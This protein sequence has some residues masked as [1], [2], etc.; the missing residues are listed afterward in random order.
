MCNRVHN[1]AMRS[2]V[3]LVL[4]IPQLFGERE[5][6][7]AKYRGYGLSEGRFGRIFLSISRVFVVGSVRIAAIWHVSA[8]LSNASE[9]DKAVRWLRWDWLRV[10]FGTEVGAA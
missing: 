7:H 10:M 5:M 4:S 3:A 8:A 6:K 1:P 9:M 2:T